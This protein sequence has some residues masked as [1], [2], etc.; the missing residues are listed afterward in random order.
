[1]GHKAR[2]C[3]RYMAMESNSKKISNRKGFN[4]MWR[5]AAPLMTKWKIPKAGE[6][7]VKNPHAGKMWGSPQE[8]RKY[9]LTPTRLALILEAVY[10]SGAPC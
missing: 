9:P 8:F 1:M 3:A 5:F 4:A 10:E 2:M 7:D 6:F